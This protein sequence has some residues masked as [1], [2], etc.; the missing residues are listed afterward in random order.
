MSTAQSV[1]PAHLSRHGPPYGC[2]TTTR[3]ARCMAP[4]PI[5]PRMVRRGDPAVGRSK[6]GGCGRTLSSQRSIRGSG[7]HSGPVRWRSGRRRRWCAARRR[8]AVAGGSGTDLG[9]ALEGMRVRVWRSW[10]LRLRSCPWLVLGG[11]VVVTFGLVGAR[12]RAKRE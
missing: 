2:R 3:E 9:T 4:P 10:P 12:L 7:R 8:R 6:K 1:K 5:V 11:M